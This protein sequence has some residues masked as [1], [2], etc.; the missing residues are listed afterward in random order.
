M[1][2]KP[3]VEKHARVIL[4][5]CDEVARQ[6]EGAYLTAVTDLEEAWQI[7]NSLTGPDASVL[8]I[9]KARRLILELIPLRHYLPE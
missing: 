5:T 4:V 7:A 9:Q 3:I 6:L 8:L 1:L 2:A